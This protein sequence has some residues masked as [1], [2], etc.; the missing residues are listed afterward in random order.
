[1]TTFHHITDSA[2]VTSTLDKTM[3]RRS[4][5]KTLAGVGAAALT[6]KTIGPAAAHH[7]E[8]TYTV[9]ANAN[10]RSGPGVGFGKLGVIV[11]GS[12]FKI[13]GL[14]KNGYDGVIYGGKTGWVL[15]SLIVE[16][17]S[18]GGGGVP[19]IN[20]QGWTTASVKLRQGPGTSFPVLK[21]VPGG[22]KI[23]TSTVVENG[24]R[25]V[26]DGA[27][28][29]WMSSAYISD[30]APNDPGSDYVT[31]TANVNFRT[32]PNA[33]API[34]QVIPVGSK[35]LLLFESSGDY[36]KVAYNEKEG[37]IA[38]AYWEI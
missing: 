8:Q 1:V 6:L 26:K 14:T 22:F 29:G 10:F 20:G 31:T 2:V 13:N 35:V 19:T 27:T 28:A 12:T 23:L 21:V 4:L 37:W 16:A 3:H 24:F 34:I 9:S 5:V 33:N 18:G 15:A 36:T 11:K 30:I 38:R 7:T 25:Y 32:E 17:G